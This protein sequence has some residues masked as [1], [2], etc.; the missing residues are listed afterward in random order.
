VLAVGLAAV[1]N[2]FVTRQHLARK[3][4]G[5]PRRKL[6]SETKPSAPQQQPWDLDEIPF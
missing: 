3:E 4:Q 5:E 2:S 1:I 6:V